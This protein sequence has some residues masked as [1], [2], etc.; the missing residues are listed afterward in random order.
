MEVMAM[1]PSIGIVIL[2]HESND[3]IEANND[4]T[5]YADDETSANACNVFSPALDDD[6]YDID[7]CLPARHTSRSPRRNRLDIIDR[8]HR[9]R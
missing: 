2:G 7:F 1:W 3:V 9:H 6:D 5:Q 4:D 8:H